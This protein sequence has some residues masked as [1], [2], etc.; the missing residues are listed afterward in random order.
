[1][2]VN[3]I[4]AGPAG[5][6]TAIL[7]KRFRPDAKISIFEQ[8]APDATFGFGV[9]FSDQA[10]SF[11]WVD[12]PETAALIEPRMKRWTGI[13]VV[14]RNQRIVIDGVGFAGIGRLDLLRMLHKRAASL[15]IC[16]DFTFPIDSKD[17]LPD[18]D[19]TV[20]AD[21]INSI[22]RS[23]SPTEFGA[24]ITYLTNRFAWFG[25]AREYDTL[26]QTFV[27]TPVGPMNAHHYAYAP[28]QSTFIIDMTEEAFEASGFTALSEPAYRAQCQQYFSQHLDAAA[29]VSNHSVWRRF[30]VLSCERW[31]HNNVVLVG[32]ALHTAHYSIGS[33]TRLA[34][35][36]VIA[37]VK[38]LRQTGWEI[39]DA[40]PEYQRSRQPILE[41]LTTAAQS[42]AHWYEHFDRH[43]NL[44]PWN[45]ALAYILR[46]GRIDPDRLKQLA[47]KF[48][49][50]LTARGI[51][52]EAGN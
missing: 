49:A 20:G 44:A 17:Q 15:G 34:L 26:T 5:L 52:L 16:P 41:K 40:L 36:D 50:E 38:A 19:L 45:F 13:S 28:G 29:L 24:Q 21:G 11:L 32:D 22:V 27:T 8:N 18:A 48:T 35:E 2:K 14:H 33:G 30:P 23:W 42:S 31:F 43:M 4:G 39:S 46:A 12:D 1:M 10:L 51:D 47:P 25:V 3:I 6:Y 7:L 37:L 9:V